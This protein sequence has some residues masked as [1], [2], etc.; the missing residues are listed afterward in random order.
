MNSSNS[1]NICPHCNNSNSLNARFCARCGAKLVVP[2]EVVVCHKCHTRNSP[3]AN[4]CRNCGT[5]IRSGAM[6]KICPKCG[7]EV[8]A[9]ENVCACGHSFATV[10]YVSPDTTNAVA[11]TPVTPVEQAQTETTANAKADKKA[12][13]QKSK[14]LVK[15]EYKTRSKK[16]GRA[17]AIVATLLLLLFAYAII[18]PVGR[19]IPSKIDSGFTNVGGAA[20]TRKY[21]WDEVMGSNG[22][23]DILISAFT[24]GGIGAFKGVSVPQMIMFVSSAILAITMIMHLLVVIIRIFSGRRSKKG[25]WFF[26]VMAILT[27]IVSVLGYLLQ[28]GILPEQTGVLGTIFSWFDLYKANGMM[29]GTIY[30][31]VV[32]A[33]YWLFFIYS[34]IAK[35]GRKKIVGEVQA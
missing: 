2:Q 14:K 33:Y 3:L 13:K 20:D 21:L 12:K 15:Y 24:G 9:E 10:G 19:F 11:A 31:Y 5:P 23:V 1:F 4:F 18:L 35:R 8:P 7:R 29:Y 27:T 16:S 6:T 34:H 17:F 25:N 30:I 32:P 22:L 26:L 28:V